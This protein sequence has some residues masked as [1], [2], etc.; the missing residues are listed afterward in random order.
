MADFYTNQDDAISHP[1]IVL[2]LLKKIT[3]ELGTKE[4]KGGYKKPVVNGGVTYLDY[5][6]DSRTEYIQA[7]EA[8]SDILLPQYDDRMDKDYNDY[9][10]ELLKAQ[11]KINNKDV[12]MGDEEHSKFINRKL[13]LVK[14]LFRDLNLLLKRTNYLKSAAYSESD[15]DDDDDEEEI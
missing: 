5:V 9:M 12:Y 6:P 15:L 3:V 14:R 13:F 2:E 11:E 4:F 8:L 1:K 7:I 10:E